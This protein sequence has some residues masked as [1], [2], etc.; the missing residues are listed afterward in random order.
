VTRAIAK[1][2]I[3]EQNIDQTEYRSCMTTRILKNT[4]SQ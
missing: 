1:Y 4:K 3:N 2:A